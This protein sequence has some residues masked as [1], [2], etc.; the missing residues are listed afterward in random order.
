MRWRM[1]GTTS[2]LW[3]QRAFTHG[4]A[5]LL[6]DVVVSDITSTSAS[7][8]FT[9]LSNAGEYF[10]VVLTQEAVD[11]SGAP[12]AR[13]IRLGQDGA[14]RAVRAH[15]GA[16]DFSRGAGVSFSAEDLFPDT[17]HRV[18]IIARNASGDFGPVYDEPFLTLRG[19]P[20]FRRPPTFSSV[21]SLSAEVSF[22]SGQCRSVLLGVAP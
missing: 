7:V 8:R 9:A 16:V 19:L 14:D 3:V 15:G 2:V 18:Y 13:Q 6:G 12:S 5:P 4:V 21:T 20:F 22:S 1:L 17:A 11:D 10:W